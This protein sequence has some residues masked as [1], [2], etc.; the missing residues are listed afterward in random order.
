VT[1]LGPHPIPF[2][3]GQ[4][5]WS[6]REPDINLTFRAVEFW[7]GE[8]DGLATDAILSHRSWISLTTATAKY[9]G[10]TTTS[11]DGVVEMCFPSRKRAC[12][13]LRK[14]I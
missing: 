11:W 3:F 12:A 14:Y 1:N 7:L 5:P 4:R 8:P 2:G 13:K 6:E 9:F 10:E